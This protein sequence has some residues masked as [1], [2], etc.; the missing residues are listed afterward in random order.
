MG[1]LLKRLFWKKTGSVLPHA[2]AP[3]LQEGKNLNFCLE[4][5]VN[6]RGPVASSLWWCLGSTADLQGAEKVEDLQK[7]HRVQGRIGEVVSALGY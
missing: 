6:N 3:D 4:T 7:T 5:Q 1:Q 2:I